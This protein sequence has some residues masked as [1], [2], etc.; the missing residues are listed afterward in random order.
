MVG[1]IPPTPMYAW[2][3]LFLILTAE[4]N[5]EIINQFS[6][7]S[8]INNIS[9]FLMIILQQENRK[10]AGA[11]V[12]PSSRLSLSLKRVSTSFTSLS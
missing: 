6:I 9:A 2:P 7:Y 8:N 3:D 11:E 12:M 4:N 1:G 10:Q 5:T